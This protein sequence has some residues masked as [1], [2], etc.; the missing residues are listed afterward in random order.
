MNNLF[1]AVFTGGECPLPFLIKQEIEGKNALIIAAD[2]GLSCVQEAGLKPDYIIGDMDS[3]DAQLL[4]AYPDECVIRHSRDKDYTDT[5]LAFKLAVEKGC[6]EI[7][8]I[9][10][11]GGRIDHLFGIRSLFERELF[12]RRWIT[13]NADIWCIEAMADDSK[14]SMAVNALSM[15]LVPQKDALVSVFPLGEGPWEAESKW[16]KWPLK[17]LKWDRGFFGL[18][19]VALSGEF[20]IKAEKGRFIVILPMPLN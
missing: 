17:G 20:F 6:G 8:I 13:A 12:P 9:G 10:G 7:W 3:V 14:P 18:S 2:S 15:K 11:G 19:N 5:E 16:L 4:D 1:G